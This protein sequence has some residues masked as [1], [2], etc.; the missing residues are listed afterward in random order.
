LVD[1]IFLLSRGIEIESFVGKLESKESSTIGDSSM[2]SKEGSCQG[3][4]QCLEAP[5]GATQQ[6]PCLRGMGET[7]FFFWE[8][9]LPPSSLSLEES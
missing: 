2:D 6:D 7:P 4:L 5:Q 8:Q 9:H 1:L 3:E